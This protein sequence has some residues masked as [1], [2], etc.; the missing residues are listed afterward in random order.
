MKFTHDSLG[1]ISVKWK[2]TGYKQPIFEGP[3][4]HCDEIGR[5]GYSHT[6]SMCVF[7]VST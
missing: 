4:V 5:W 7:Y 6:V 2:E 3:K 1:L